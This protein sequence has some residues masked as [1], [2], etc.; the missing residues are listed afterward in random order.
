M[1]GQRP[2]RKQIAGKR[3][4][5]ARHAVSERNHGAASQRVEQAAEQ[6]GPKK[7]SGRERQNVPANLVGGDPEEIRQHQRKG[8]EDRVVE[9]RLRDHQHEADQRAL[10]IKREQGVRHF[11]QR[12][13]IAHP[14]SDLRPRMPARILQLPCGRTL[15]VIDDFVR[16]IGPA[17]DHQPAR[18]FRNPHPHHEH[19]EAETSAGEIGQPPAEIGADQQ[20]IEQH[21]C[22]GRAH[23]RADPETAVDNE[24]GPS[25]IT[26]RHQ[27]LDRRIYRGVFAA[28]AGAGKKPK[29]RVA[30]DI[31]GQR[32]R[33]RGREIERQRDEKQSLAPD[34]VGEPA[35]AE[36]PEHGAGEVRAVGKSDVEIGKMQRRAFLQR[37]RQRTGQRYLQPVQN[38]G[39]AERQNDPC[40]KTAPAQ[41]VE[42]GGNTGLD[43]AI[44]VARRH[45]PGWRAIVRRR[46]GLHIH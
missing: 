45:A 35:E 36:R 39:D 44:V 8:E 18:A 5:H 22:A 2:D 28:D 37:S 38:P 24:V 27:F 23:R 4:Q 30:C 10:A 7:I 15:D 11:A 40:M 34:P 33:G 9:E 3:Q 42:T 13:V 14:Q 20:R 31:P 1:R 17:V 16:L 21:D 6:Q 32:G 19:D 25:A 43:D 26:R 41:T 46:T 29:Q 12:G